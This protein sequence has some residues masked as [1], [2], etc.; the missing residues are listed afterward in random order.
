MGTGF[1]NTI[2]NIPGIISPIITAA[3][4]QNELVSEWQIVFY[5][6]AAVSI[7]GAVFYVVFG[8]GE[9]QPWAIQETDDIQSSRQTV[10]SNVS[11][12]ILEENIVAV[13][14]E[15]KI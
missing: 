15:P 8:S 1:A 7:F 5:F 10:L 12:D 3:I 2:S 6:T 14:R 9:V 11:L 4:V 13:I